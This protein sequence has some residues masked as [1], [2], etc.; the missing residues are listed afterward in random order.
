MGCGACV[1]CQRYSASVTTGLLDNGTILHLRVMRRSF[2]T[3]E[4][5]PLTSQPIPR[6]LIQ[7]YASGT[8]FLTF[9][10]A[11]WALLTMSALTPQQRVFLIVM[12]VIVAGMLGYAAI[13]LLRAAQHLPQT[14]APDASTQGRTVGKWYALIVVSE[15]VAIALASLVLGRAHDDQLIPLVVALIVGIHFLPLAA[16]FHVPVYYLTG[17]CMVVLAGCGLIA[18]FFDLTLGGPYVW[19]VVIG[20]GNTVILWSTT[21]YLLAAARQLLHGAPG[22]VFVE[23]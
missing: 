6:A 14:G 13:K 21:L 7:G 16:L 19:S 18:L 23:P 4:E 10:G 22:T 2:P 17:V 11:I 5:T 9:F 8:L 20:L 15:F 12:V 1:P 3:S